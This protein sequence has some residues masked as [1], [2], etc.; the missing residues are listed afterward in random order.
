MSKNQVTEKKK[1][2]ENAAAVMSVILSVIAIVAAIFSWY[3]I[4]LTIGV[5][6]VSLPS[7][8]I[9]VFLLSKEKG[10]KVVPILSLICNS[11]AWA[12]VGIMLIG[13]TYI[14]VSNFLGI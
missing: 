10:G 3:F 8:I 1:E 7:I 2:K 14:Y 13:E 12:V 5:L 4:M 6:L 11:I 9:S